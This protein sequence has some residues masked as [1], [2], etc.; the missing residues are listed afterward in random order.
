MY[1]YLPTL[2]RLIDAIRCIVVVVVRQSD[3]QQVVL[4]RLQ[5]EYAQR[6]RNLF[7]LKSVFINT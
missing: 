7:F 4:I 3:H 6:V 1:T 2:V 5:P